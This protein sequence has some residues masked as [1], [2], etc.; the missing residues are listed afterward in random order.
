M[1]GRYYLYRLVLL[2]ISLDKLKLLARIPLGI[3]LFGDAAR[4]VLDYR[5]GCLHYVGGAAVITFQTEQAAFRII[6][7]EVKYVLDLRAAEG[8]YRL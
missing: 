7:F 6:L 8:V 4:I 1:Y 2:G 3:A 5:I